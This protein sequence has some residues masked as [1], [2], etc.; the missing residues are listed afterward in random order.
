MPTVHPA[1]NKIV[2]EYK[3]KN[4][5]DF[6]IAPVEGFGIQRFVAEAKDKMSTWDMYAGATPFVEVQALVEADVIEPWD[7]YIPDDVK[8]DVIASCYEEG[9]INGKLYCFPIF[10]DII[11][12]GWNSSITE[13]A[14]TGVPK[15]WDE[16][17]DFGRQVQQGGHAPYGLVFDAHGWRS[18]APIAHSYSTNTYTPEGYFDFTS[19]ASVYALETMKKIMQYAPPDILNPG[20][21]DGGVN[22][23]PDEVHFAAQEAAY[24]IKYQNAPLRFANSWEDPSKVGLAGLPKAPNGEGATVFWNT[25]AVL[26]KYGQN[27]E[28]AIDFLLFMLKNE[29]LWRESIVGKDIRSGHLP[30][31]QSIWDG[32]KANPPEWLKGVDYPF[33]ILEQLKISKAIKNTKF[34]IQQFFVGQP[35]WEK[36]LKGE[37]SDP[38]VAL[39]E[40]MDAVQA[41]I[42][43]AG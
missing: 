15:T 14:G 32:W 27:K 6:Q 42:K 4:P 34:G 40:T 21:T 20:T 2:E 19:E 18:L 43:K 39:K 30:S 36:Y 26:M 37:V 17:I 3:Q 7:E 12:L 13:K 24:Y 28:K 8:K 1:I 5:I 29:E 23:T 16:F 25:G 9:T 22:N 41:E 10:L 35:Y 11:T 38:R 31:L 33:L